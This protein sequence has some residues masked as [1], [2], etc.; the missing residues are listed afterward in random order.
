[1]DKEAQLRALRELGDVHSVN[2][3]NKS[4]NS[5]V[6]VVKY[7]DALRRKATTI[8]EVDLIDLIM[9]C[10]FYEGKNKVTG[11]IHGDPVRDTAVV[12]AEVKTNNNEK[13][14]RKAYHREYMRKRR[15]K[16]AIKGG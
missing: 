2:N 5:D 7:L 4:V 3:V 14:D 16:S 1:M 12:E 8:E 13:T 6:D 11:R 15:L 9:K 10:L